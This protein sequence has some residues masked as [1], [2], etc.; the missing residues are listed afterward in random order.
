MMD[1]VIL[2]EAIERTSTEESE[3]LEC[4]RKLGKGLIASGTSVGVVENT[5]TEIALA[6]DTEC[7][8][9]A[10]P[11]YIPLITFLPSARV[12]LSVTSILSEDLQSAAIGLGEMVILMISIALGVLLGTLVISP[13]KFVPVA[14]RG[15]QFHDQ[16]T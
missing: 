1:A 2:P 15:S 11:N 16:R 14:A 9:M 7:E 4:L 6:Y 8:I 10:L 3:L 5:L 12:L 13:Y